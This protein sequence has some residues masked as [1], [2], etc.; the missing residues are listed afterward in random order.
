MKNYYKIICILGVPHLSSTT[1][2]NILQS[3]LFGGRT[4]ILLVPGENPD[5]EKTIKTLE[6]I[7]GGR[8]TI[9]DIRPYALENLPKGFENGL[10]SP[11]GGKK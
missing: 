3:P 11:D 5:R 8:I 4:I 10:P 1:Q 2:I 9:Q 6:T 7:T